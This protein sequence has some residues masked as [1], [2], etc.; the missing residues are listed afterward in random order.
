MENYDAIVIGVGL[1][2]TTA[3]ILLANSGKRFFRSIRIINQG[4][5]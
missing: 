2:G 1:V 3:V 5:G 4:A